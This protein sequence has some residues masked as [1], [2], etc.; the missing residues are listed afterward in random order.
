MPGQAVVTIKGKQWTVDVA[1]TYLELTYGLGMLM[2]M[3]TGTGMLFDVGSEQTIEVTT[4]SMLFP[5]DIEILQQ[6]A[7]FNLNPVSSRNVLGLVV[8][9]TVGEF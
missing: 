8:N 3:A 9:L 5:L 6:D 1:C 4:A 2:E 7:L